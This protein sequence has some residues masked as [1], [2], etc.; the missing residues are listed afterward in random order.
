[1]RLYTIGD[2]RLGHIGRNANV[3]THM[4][5]GPHQAAGELDPESTG[6]H[7]TERHGSWA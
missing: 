5:R 7:E 4:I 1:M 6:R 2:A 3:A